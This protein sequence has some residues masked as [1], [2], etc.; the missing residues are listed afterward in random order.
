[1]IGTL[2]SQG[3]SM[4]PFFENPANAELKYRK[5]ETQCPFGIPNGARGN[6]SPLAV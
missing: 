3:K 2:Y 6:V 5:D 4:I 1:M